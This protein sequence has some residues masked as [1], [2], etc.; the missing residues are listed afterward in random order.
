MEH[1]RPTEREALLNPVF[2]ALVLANAAAGH[3]RRTERPMP[4]GLCFLTVPI[5]LHA[6]TRAALPRKVTTKPGSWL[7][8]HPLLRAG[9]AARA[10]ATAPAVR[11]GLREGL[12]AGALGVSGDCI[13]GKPPRRRA[14]V[15]LSEET[16]EILKRA[17]FAGGWL[18]LAGSP[19]GIYAMWRVRP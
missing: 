16:D 17:E 3:T 18:G 1:A 8:K 13:S 11:A 12:R 14:A 15:P 10:R 9:F 5:A 6:P 4:L 7:E 2:V 19:V